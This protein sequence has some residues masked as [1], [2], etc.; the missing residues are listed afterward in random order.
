VLRRVHDFD[1]TILSEIE[2]VGS[3]I[4][5]APSPRRET[6]ATEAEVADRVRFEWLGPTTTPELGYDFVTGVRLPSRH[7]RPG[8]RREHVLQ[9]LKTDGH[10]MIVEP[11]AHD[12]LKDN[13]NPIGRIYYSAS[14]LLCTP[15]SRSQEVGLCLGAQA[16]EARIREVVTAGGSHAF[17][18][19]L[20]RPSTSCTS[21][22]LNGAARAIHREPNGGSEEPQP[23]PAHCPRP[24]NSRC[25]CTT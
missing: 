16:G 6:A 14:T 19:R 8:R 9:S 13:L 5:T 20:R 7:G 4:M 23:K 24:V 25:P 21:P 1:G 2:V 10:W 17:G 15:C 11:F 3:T 18:E 22:A 12:D